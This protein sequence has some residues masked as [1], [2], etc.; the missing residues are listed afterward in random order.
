MG[1]EEKFSI[2][3]FQFSIFNRVINN[4]LLQVKIKQRL[5]KLA[6]GDYDNIECWQ[7]VEAFNKVQVDWVRA[8]LGG[9]NL[10]KEGDE[11]SKRRVDDLQVLLASVP[12]KGVNKDLFFESVA[13]PEDYLEFKRVVVQGSH[14]DC[15]GQLRRFRV[16]LAEEANVEDYLRDT[17]TRPDWEWGE[18]FCTLAGNQVRVYTNGDFAVQEGSL[19]YYRLP[20]HVLFAG[21]VDPSSGVVAVK[22]V[23]CRFKDDVVEVLIDL[24][25]AQL[26]GDIESFNQMS[27]N[28]QGADALN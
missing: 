7:I 27:R 28:K 18:T 20:R 1:K 14:K 23:V 2:F 8:Q 19:S 26:A 11:M 10:R 4:F 21:C 12:L 3:N 13:L 25:A 24:T 5:N 17:N 16:D 9:N 6:S 15:P 22:D